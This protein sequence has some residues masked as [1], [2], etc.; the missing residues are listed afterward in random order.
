MQVLDYLN[1]YQKV[2]F[3]ELPF[4]EV[5]ALLLAMVSYF[6][7]DELNNQKTIYS[8]EDL[9]KRI[10]E[11]KPPHKTTER[12]LKYIEMTFSYWKKKNMKII[13]ERSFQNYY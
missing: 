5:D 1:K 10:N 6:P 3:K 7:F 11:Y 13:K 9:L 2:E 12:K 4:N 8:S